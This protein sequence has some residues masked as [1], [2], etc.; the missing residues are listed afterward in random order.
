MIL[1]TKEWLRIQRINPDKQFKQFRL[2]FNRDN[3]CTVYYKATLL[4]RVKYIVEFNNLM[5]AIR[6]EVL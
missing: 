1:L 5:Y 3:S 2:M 6:G 4:R